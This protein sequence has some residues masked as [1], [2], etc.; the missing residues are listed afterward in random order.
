MLLARHQ[1]KL[2]TPTEPSGDNLAPDRVKD[3]IPDDAQISG[4]PAPG[5]EGLQ[6]NNPGWPGFKSEGWIFAGSLF[7]SLAL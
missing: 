3:E 7:V 1:W 6:T 4:D 5:R 2:P